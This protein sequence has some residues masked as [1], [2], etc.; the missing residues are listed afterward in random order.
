MAGLQ[1]TLHGFTVLDLGAGMSSALVTKF[2]AEAGARVIR[3]EPESGDPF[4]RVYPA[5]AT[6][7]H[8]KVIERVSD[9]RSESVK[10]WLSKADICVMGGEDFPGFDWRLDGAEVAARYPALTILN[11][12]GYPASLPLHGRPA[13]DILVQ[14]RSGFCFEHYSDKP[15]VAGFP[16]AIYG[17]ALLGLIALLGAFYSR[18]ASGTGKL[19][20]VSLFEG[21]IS[22]CLPYWIHAEKPDKRLTFNIPKDPYPLIFRCKDGKYIHFVLGSAGSKGRLYRILKIDD[23]TVAPDDAGFPNPFGPAKTFFGDIDT[24]AAHVAN[25]N[26]DELV[27]AIRAAEVAV[28]YVLAPGECWN[29]PQV[30]HNQIL[31]RGPGHERYV[32]PPIEAAWTAPSSTGVAEPKTEGPFPLSGVRVLDFGALV[33][34]P[35]GSVPLG[36]LGADVIKVEALTGDVNR[37][38]PRSFFCC[39]RGKRSI[40]VDMKT[41]EGAEI[42]RRLCR[43]ADIAT[44]NFRP[45]VS[46]RLGVDP[47]SLQKLK[48]DMVALETTGYG[49]SGPSGL[50]PGYDMVLQAFCG[51]EATAGGE[52][53]P[54]LWNRT[55]M[56]DFAAGL[57]GSVA[58]LVALIHRR[59]TGAGASVST[60]LLNAGLFMFS[61][62]VQRAN[63]E[64]AG[65]RKLNG[66]QTGF[67]PAEAL[68]RTAD[69]WI[70]VHAPSEET[71]QAL[72]RVLG[73]ETSAFP[74]RAAWANREHTVL[75]EAIASFS[76]DALLARLDEAHVWAEAV[77][78]D[79]SIWLDDP[80]LIAGGTAISWNDPKYGETAILGAMF[81]I[82]GTPHARLHDAPTLGRDTREI[83][84]E[85]GYSHREIEALFASKVVL[86]TI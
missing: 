27:A 73:L 34:G 58:M 35:Y 62:L 43:N 2:L 50:R 64:F 7:H 13:S 48:Q 65:I 76:Q 77:L 79:G 36:D 20:S 17:T 30:E 57:C 10:D 53:N 45:G 82:A 60:S 67:H 11:I 55:S 59:R 38:I 51:F 24:L 15:Y 33:A 23:P 14:A 6:W 37:T 47:I 26:S 25:F 63:G 3:L 8:A 86:E 70:A 54:P 44:N 84:S 40:A 85:L 66:T 78:E 75:S 1:D 29:D 42:V 81:Q 72:L 21:T 18:L 69:G 28:E 49:S 5:Y 31:R 68:Y 9:I 52:G 74:P 39:N 32:G 83:L 56:L 80:A 61:E 16:A 46:A 22:W 4:Y 19:A 12:T 41:P 71:S